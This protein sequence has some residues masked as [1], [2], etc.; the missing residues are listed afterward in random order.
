MNIINRVQRIANRLVGA[1]YWLS[2]VGEKDDFGD[3]IKDIII[4][5]KTKMGPW[6]LMTERSYQQYGIGKLGMGYGQKYKKQSDGKWLKIEGSKKTAKEIARTILQ[7]IGGHKFL[8]M[9]GAKNLVAYPN[10]L[11]FR[12]PGNGF[13][14]FNYVKITLNGMDTYDIEMGNF[15]ASV[16]KKEKE[17][18]G[19]YDDQLVELLEK[20]TGL[21][22]S[23][24]RIGSK[25]TTLEGHLAYGKSFG[26]KENQ[27]WIGTFTVHGE[28]SAV[29]TTDDFRRKWGVPQDGYEI[30]KVKIT[31]KEI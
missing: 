15:R 21:R 10:G 16:Y 28:Q 14:K 11:S 17:L 9:T 25:I 4:D 5:G 6:G 13:S 23:M 20:Y 18:N 1:K 2:P 8:I 7:Q 30:K 22:F 29:E 3:K 26:D 31:I 12:L 27:P 24:G 19:I